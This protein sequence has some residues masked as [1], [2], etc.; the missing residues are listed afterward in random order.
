[1]NT[2]TKQTITNLFST[3]LGFTP[4]LAIT[5]DDD[6]VYLD[7]K[8]EPQDSGVLIGYQGETLNALQLIVSLVYQRQEGV[9]KPIRLN[10][11]DYRQKKQ[12]NL[13][14]QARNAA[15]RAVAENQPVT[16]SGLSSYE[17]RLVHSY[18]TDDPSVETHSEGE[19]PYR[20]LIISPT[21]K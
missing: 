9:W 21:Q 13:E 19:P 17:R 4:D 12:L 7:L 5:E 8:L 1:M 3:L 20:V 6:Q 11:N 10:I 14:N 15:A 2:N 16:L 18:L